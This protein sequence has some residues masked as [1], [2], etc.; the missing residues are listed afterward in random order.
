[1]LITFLLSQAPRLAM[2]WGTWSNEELDLDILL[3]S[4]AVLHWKGDAL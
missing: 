2:E 1:M 3:E 4:I